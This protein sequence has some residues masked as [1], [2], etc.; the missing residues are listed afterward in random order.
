MPGGLTI[1]SWY[2]RSHWQH[3]AH[4]AR[5]VSMHKAH[6]QP[7]P[8]T[9]V[10]YDRLQDLSLVNAYQWKGSL[11]EEMLF[12]SAP[13]AAGAPDIVWTVRRGGRCEQ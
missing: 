10:H 8:P 2:N 13:R 3:P 1:Q 7:G 11:R 5:P 12:E 4:P 9:D 6:G